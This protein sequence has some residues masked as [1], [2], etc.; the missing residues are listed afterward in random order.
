MT[1]TKAGSGFVPM[2][3]G[4]I[5]ASVADGEKS[6]V[7][8]EAYDGSS[9][10]PEDCPLVL[11]VVSEEAVQQFVA[12]PGDLGLARAYLT[13]SIE[14]V[15]GVHPA[16]PHD[17]FG[18]LEI[19]RKKM[20]H[21]PDLATTLR[22]LRSVGV[23][24]INPKV[25]I[26]EMEI[27]A[28]WR[29]ALSGEGRHTRE[30]DSRSVSYHYDVSNRFYE[31]VLGPSMTYTCACYPTADATLEEAQENKYRLV[32]DKLG[33]SEGDRLLDV[34]C[35]WGGMVRYA[36]RR[37][38]RAIGVTL[39]KEQASWAQ[40]AIE[41]EG[42]GDL[43]EVRLQDY[44]DVPESAF[45]AI[46]SIG[47]TEHIGRENYPAYFAKLRSMV[48]P[49]GLL[50]NHCITRPDNTRTTKAGAFID[51]YIFPD[52][53]LAGAATVQLEAENVGFEVVHTENLRPHYGFTLREWC[54]NLE[55]HWDEAV[56]EVG[57]PMA[58]LWGL[59]MGA[60][61]YGFETNVVQLHQVLAVN[62][63]DEAGKPWDVPLRQWWKA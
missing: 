60:C 25:P 36:A 2:T 13:G 7:R 14:I 49:G 37:G 52:G 17:L 48:K 22:I 26:P 53:E 24:G 35:G 20:A 55:E 30:R 32:F 16:A 23:S 54:A 47:I 50:L 44:R 1:R 38:V 4:E 40:E 11:R 3:I 15:R 34:G 28:P 46:S 45:D 56:E 59:Y 27:V 5:L 21:K 41:K 57:L 43:A 6:P 51:R 33:L 10:G 31:W 39:S 63:D 58:K 18:A 29:R 19:L 12:A 42:L 8:I 61:Q 9:F 62:L